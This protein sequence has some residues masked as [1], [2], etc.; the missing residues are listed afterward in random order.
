MDCD[1][2]S[3][4]EVSMNEIT[5]YIVHVYDWTAELV[6]IASNVSQNVYLFFNIKSEIHQSFYSLWIHNWKAQI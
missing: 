5:E 6:I 1:V 4:V 3:I 2:S